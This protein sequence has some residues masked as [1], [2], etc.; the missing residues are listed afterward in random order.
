M[1]VTTHKKTKSESVLVIVLLVVA[2]TLVQQGTT[3]TGDAG[4]SGISSGLFPLVV[5]S[6]LALC[7]LMLAREVLTGGLCNQGNDTA[8]YVE[9]PPRLAPTSHLLWVFAGLVIQILTI[10]HLGFV[11]A[12]ATLMVLVAR[13][14]RGPQPASR[15]LLDIAIA[16]A[17]TLPVQ[18]LFTRFLGLNLPLLPFLGS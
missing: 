1:S 2:G 9:A 3:L 6:G 12:S 18:Q 13:G 7:A 16:L 8:P 11:L 17:V 10:A 14:F 4:Y 15:W 5:G